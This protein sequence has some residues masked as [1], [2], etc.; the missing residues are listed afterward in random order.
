MKNG[1]FI[2]GTTNVSQW[3]NLNSE[4]KSTIFFQS[5]NYIMQKINNFALPLL[6][7]RR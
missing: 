6:N 1:V 7:K 3:Y 5:G 4:S 2:R